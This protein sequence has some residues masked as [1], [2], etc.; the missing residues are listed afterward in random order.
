MEE[1]GIIIALDGTSCVVEVGAADACSGCQTRCASGGEGLPRQ[2]TVRKPEFDLQLGD[3][4]VVG[5]SARR[6]LFAAGMF[7]LGSLLSLFI[8]ASV[9]HFAVGRVWPA[10]VD[11]GALSGGAIAFSLGLWAAKKWNFI[12]SLA[13]APVISRRLVT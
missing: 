2:L 13:S 1:V 3:R 12:E 11:L 7:Y 8:G 6:T 4:V 10:A 5:I 9:G